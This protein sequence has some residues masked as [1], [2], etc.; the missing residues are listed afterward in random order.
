MYS[1]EAASA[2]IFTQ[3]IFRD[4]ENNYYQ[5]FCLAM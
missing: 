1:I 4:T 5:L 2:N 3:A